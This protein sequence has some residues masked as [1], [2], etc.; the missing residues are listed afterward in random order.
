MDS[1]P[2]DWMRVVSVNLLGPMLAIKHSAPHMAA[3]GSIVITSSLNAVQP[4]AGMSAYC[5]SKAA[6]AMLAEVAAME[7]GPAASGST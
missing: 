5:T 4:A 3:G 6:A 7:L 2:T 1:D